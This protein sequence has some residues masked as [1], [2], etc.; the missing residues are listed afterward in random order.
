[1]TR[2]IIDRLFFLFSGRSAQVEENLYIDCDVAFE[3]DAGPTWPTRKFTRGE[4]FSYSEDIAVEARRPGRTVP[5]RPCTEQ[6]RSKSD[7]EKAPATIFRT[8]R[9]D[10]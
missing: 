6:K 8:E 5:D 4:R 10:P 7:R 1:M 2:K 9:G 3:E